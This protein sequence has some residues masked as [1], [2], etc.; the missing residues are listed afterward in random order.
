VARARNRRGLPAHVLGTLHRQKNG[1]SVLRVRKCGV[2]VGKM[3]DEVLS[4]GKGRSVSSI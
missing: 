2:G 1:T 3:S 4:V